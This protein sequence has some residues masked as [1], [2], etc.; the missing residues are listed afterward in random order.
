MLVLT[1]DLITVELIRY[2]QRLYELD[3]ENVDLLRSFDID[4][5]DREFVAAQAG[6]GIAVGHALA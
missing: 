6:D 3:G 4:P 1:T 5:N 2:R